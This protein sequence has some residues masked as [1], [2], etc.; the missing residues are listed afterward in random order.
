MPP[1]RPQEAFFDKSC[2]EEFYYFN[3]ILL[4]FNSL[5]F[6]LMSEQ[7]SALDYS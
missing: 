6:P 7:L 3:L 4:L 5:L 2:D 1:K